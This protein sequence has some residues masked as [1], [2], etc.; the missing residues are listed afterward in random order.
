MN[1]IKPKKR[2]WI[3][4]GVALGVCVVIVLL[5]GPFSYSSVCKHCGR[6]C[7]THEWHVPILEIPLVWYSN[8]SESPVSRVLA[9]RDLISPHSH[10]WLFN[11]GGGFFVVCALGRGSALASTVNSEKVA[12][13]IEDVYEFEDQAMMKRLT[14]LIFDEE[15]SREARF[16]ANL[17]PEQRFADKAEF[18]AWLQRWAEHDE[19]AAKLIGR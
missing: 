19:T 12:R 18:C 17:V 15:N 5:I 8:E 14:E 7:H 2:R 11:Q 1:A 3:R 16:I 9:T 13:L 4:R 6:W 10:E